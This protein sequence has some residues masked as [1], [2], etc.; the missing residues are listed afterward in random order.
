MRK[1]V[2]ETVKRISLCKVKICFAL[3][4]YNVRDRARSTHGE[5][6][7]IILKFI[8]LKG[9]N[10]LRNQS[11]ACKIILKYTLENKRINLL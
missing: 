2:Y 4:N 5:K 6:I 3:T 10:Y 1:Y 7:R 11:S 8:K 9:L